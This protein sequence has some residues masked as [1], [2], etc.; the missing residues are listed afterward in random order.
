MRALVKSSP[1]PGIWMEDIDE[2]SVGPNDVLI[3]ITKTSICGTDL[4]I[5]AW[6]EWAQ[7]TIPVPMAVGHEY[8]GV[9]AGL[10]SEVE[11]IHIGQR[12]SGEGH[13]VCGRCRNCQAGRRHLCINTVGVGVNRPGAFA[14]YLAIP[15]SNV[16][17]IPDDI[18]DDIAAILDPLGNAV[19][20]ALHFDL[21]G[22]DVLITGAGPIGIMAVVIARHV[23]ARYIVVTDVNEY[24]L[25]LSQTMGADREMNVLTE[26]LDEV[27]AELDMCEGF[28][29]GLEMSGQPSALHDMITHMD[30]GGEI[31]LLGIPPKQAPIDWND[32]VFKGLTLQGIYGRRMFE[33]WYKML[34]M[35]QTGLDVSGVITHHFPADDYEAAFDVMRSGECGKVILNWE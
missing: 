15:G 1:K 24:R 22:E 25:H 21:V 6:D 19:H 10:G 3:K 9:V 34:A 14:E 35:L 18:P 11:G 32:I 26:S 28:D 17:P 4:H 5:V 8:V 2:P 13:I 23:G 29:V 31:A 12:V 16:Q 7:S 30:N 33:T 27:M 20:T